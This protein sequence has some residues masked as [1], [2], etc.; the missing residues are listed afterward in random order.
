MPEIIY[1]IYFY[2]RLHVT[3]RSFQKL[4]QPLRLALSN[5][6]PRQSK[7]HL[8]FLHQEHY[9]TVEENQNHHLPLHHLTGHLS[10]I[11][12]SFMWLISNQLLR[13]Y[14]YVIVDLYLVMKGLPL[15]IQTYPSRQF[16]KQKTIKLLQKDA[17][18]DSTNPQ[19]SS[20]GQKISNLIPT[21]KKI[22]SKQKPR[23]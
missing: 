22:Q 9:L 7:Y 23:K 5:F 19:F 14:Y 1:Q 21:E 8:Y 4:K 2:D 12:Y 3:P 13:K 10:G 11:S 15:V 6:H 18:Y 20:M 17:I 16:Q